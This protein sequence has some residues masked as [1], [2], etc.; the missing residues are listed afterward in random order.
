MGTLLCLGPAVQVQHEQLCDLR[1]GGSGSEQFQSQDM[2]LVRIMMHYFY[3]V[4]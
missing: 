4:H 1:R 3:G 2:S